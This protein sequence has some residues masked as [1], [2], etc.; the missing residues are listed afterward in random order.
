MKASVGSEML[1]RLNGFAEALNDTDV[2]SDRFTCRR[3]VLNLIPTPY[4]PEAVRETRR[5][6][7]ASQA[8]FAK[9]LGV[10]TKT[11]QAWEQGT[12]TPR[13]MACRFMDEIRNNPQYWLERFR[14]SLISK[15]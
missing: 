13:D 15:D 1:K 4:S 2:I 9:F 6:L 10:K 3:V 7:G 11:V 8:M 5:I 14:G 12:N